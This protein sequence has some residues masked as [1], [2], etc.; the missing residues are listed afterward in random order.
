MRVADGAELTYLDPDDTIISEEKVGQGRIRIA[1]RANDCRHFEQNAD[2]KEC[3]PMGRLVFFIAGGRTDKALQFETKAW[4]SIRGLRKVLVAAEKLGPLTGRTFALSVKFERK[5]ESTFPIVSIE[6]VEQVQV[7]TEKDV[8]LADALIPL[9][10][11]LDAE[12]VDGVRASLAA[13]L[14]VTTPGWRERE[15]VIGRIQEVGIFPA[16]RKTLERYQA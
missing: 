9:R 3:R 10:V 4:G 13:V 12:D 1:C 6:E 2:K 16:A 5:G 8:T 15:D 11:A 14:D 7:N